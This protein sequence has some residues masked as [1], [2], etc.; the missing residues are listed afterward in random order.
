MSLF[1]L[2]RKATDGLNQDVSTV[3]QLASSETFS[4]RN[5]GNSQG[6]RTVRCW[7]PDTKEANLMTRQS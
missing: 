7:R 3:R 2:L 4:H 1:V 5:F 6:A